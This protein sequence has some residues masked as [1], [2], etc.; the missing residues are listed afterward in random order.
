MAQIDLGKL[1]F[2]WK[3]QWTTS[4]AYESD[5]VVYHL[6]SA[7][8][9]VTDVASS[10]TTAPNVSTSFEKI[11]QGLQHLGAYSSSTT[12][13]PGDL[14]TY[15]NAWYIYKQVAAASGNLPTVTAN[16]D[17]VV[18]A[19]P[20]AVTTT[21]GD[22][23]TRDKEHNLIRFP[24]GTKGQTLKAKEDPYETLTTDNS[25]D[26]VV[27][28]TSGRYANIHE[29]NSTHGSGTLL[30]GDASTQ[31]TPTLTRGQK[32]TFIFAANGLTYSFKDPTDGS[33]SGA[34]S[35]GRLTTA[36]GVDVV[37]ITNGGTI[38]F[39]PNA[40]TPNSVVIRDEA[41][42]GDVATITVI[43]MRHTVEWSGG[44]SNAALT[45]ADGNTDFDKGVGKTRVQGHDIPLKKADPAPTLF[46]S[47]Y[48]TYTESL[49][50]TPTW[51]AAFGK[52]QKYAN[53]ITGSCYRQGGVITSDGLPMH[54]G[55]PYHDSNAYTYGMGG[56]VGSSVGRQSVYPNLQSSSLRVPLFFKKA[57]AGHSDYAKFLTDM[58][59]SSLGY[60]KNTMRPKI[61]EAHKDY[62]CGYYLAENGILFFAGYNGYGLMGNGGSSYNFYELVACPFYNDSGTQLTGANYPKI[63]QIAYTGASNNYTDGDYQ[64]C[65]ALDTDG[66]VYT[67]GY[68]GNYNLGRGGTSTSYYFQAIS[69][70]KSAFGNEKVIYITTS[71]HSS[72]TSHSGAITESGKLYLW[73]YNG[74]GNC[75]NGSTTAISA[76][77]NASDNSN[78][79]IYGKTVDHV[80]LNN[81]AGHN[82]THCMTTDGKLHACGYMEDYGMY[83]GVASANNASRGNFGEFTHGSDT[84]FWNSDNQKVISFWM[85]GGR[86]PVTY[87]I[88]DGGDSG[89]PKLYACGD[90]AYGSQGT[91][92]T[93]SSSGNTSTAIGA[94]KGGECQFTTFGDD[95]VGSD[96][97]RPNE[98]SGTRSTFEDST[99]ANYQQL[100]IGKIV[101]VATSNYHQNSA[102]KAMA[103]DE[104]GQVYITGYWGYMPDYH[105][106]RDDG[107]QFESTNNYINRWVPCFSQ[108]EP[109]VDVAFVGNNSTSEE[110]WL[111]IGKSGTCYTGGY[112]GWYQNGAT[113]QGT[114]S[115]Q[116]MEINSYAGN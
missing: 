46:N 41:N 11:T 102:T 71:E 49:R 111:F 67:V 39:E 90:N 84:G 56:G 16:W 50:A 88:T 45:F 3:G 31:A 82:M 101:K 83:A 47:D 74:Y 43:D 9:C 97:S 68:G 51:A 42:Q 58:N 2:T 60:T 57:I 73:G 32:Y 91:N 23:A 22:L 21:S 114:Y 26:Y 36:E 113:D 81:S 28:T 96:N 48:N 66:I 6:N 89:E 59:G 85:S 53:S 99:H 86:Y 65:V 104:N 109:V 105:F 13:Y 92:T 7:Y 69:S 106:E 110:G 94:W 4:T 79:S 17:V 95:E 40:S 93:Y 77:Y 27:N 64:S 25:F 38:V 76:P 116:A 87:M 18:P 10:N 70:N 115:L 72:G 103:L 61:I 112:S 62:R 24:I 44:T 37:S 20:Q 29:A 78:S 1:K 108:P 63:A 35:G 30:L 98:V 107:A 33:Y 75:G 54:W 34:G 5:D 52:G 8:V 55:N 100:K 19:A 80:V 12:Y 14:V 15:L